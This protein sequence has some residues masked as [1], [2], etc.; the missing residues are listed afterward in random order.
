MNRAER[1]ETTSTVE[2]LNADIGATK[3]ST[4]TMEVDEGDR[5]DSDEESTSSKE[6]VDEEG[7]IEVN[8]LQFDCPAE[9]DYSDEPQ[10]SGSDLAFQIDPSTGRL[11]DDWYELDEIDPMDLDGIS[12]EIEVDEGYIGPMID[13]DDENNWDSD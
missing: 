3:D 10:N 4:H 11:L 12:D 13:S 5:V 9:D 1:S 6:D 2:P 7:D 8:T